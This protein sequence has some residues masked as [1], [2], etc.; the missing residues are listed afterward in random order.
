MK[1]TRF[2]LLILASGLLCFGQA[3]AEEGAEAELRPVAIWEPMGAF[4][5]GL[6]F[7]NNVLRSSLGDEDSAFVL[8][9]GDA[10]LMRYS[11]TGSLLTL[12]VLGEDIRYFDAP[13]VDYEQFLYGSAELATPVGS[14][15][16]V[17]ISGSYLYQHQVVDASATEIDQ[18]RVLVLGHSATLR[19]YWEHAFDSRWAARIE[20]S[21]MRQIY[22]H[23]LDD[24]WETEQIGSLIY[25]YG[26]RSEASAAYRTALRHYDTREQY[27]EA[28]AVIP[29]TH[30]V[31]SQNEFSSRWKHYWDA[32]RQWRTF[33]DAGFLLNRD[34]GSGY[35]DYQRVRLRQEIRWENERW[36]IKANAR[37]G[38]YYYELQKIGAEH[39][40]RS[41]LLLDGRIERKVNDFLSLFAAVEKEWSRSNDPLDE[42]ESWMASG[43]AGLEF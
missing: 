13:T 25:Q 24:Y 22:E 19:P 1:C 16:E 10:V 43:G 35:F 26:H 2:R 15:D 12:Y 4:T 32:D 37:F 11:E 28:G 18:R 29:D 34:N 17:G 27:D 8:T 41:Y 39:R 36:T 21:V 38:W 30:L 33:T 3:S 40:Y 23:E 31:Y 9:S 20:G 5:A 6:G 42:Y 7:R 14:L